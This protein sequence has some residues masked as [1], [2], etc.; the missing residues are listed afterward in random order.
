MSFVNQSMSVDYDIVNLRLKDWR[1]NLERLIVTT[2]SDY[3]HQFIGNLHTMNS[4]SL[5]LRK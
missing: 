3:G 5:D 1:N 2:L 4:K